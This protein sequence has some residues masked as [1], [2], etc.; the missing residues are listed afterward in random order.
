[1]CGGVQPSEKTKFTK[2]ECRFGIRESKETS[3]TRAA[4]YAKSQKG[5]DRI[6]LEMADLP[7]LE[8][9]SCVWMMGKKI[10][11]GI[12]NGFLMPGVIEGA[13]RNFELKSDIMW[14]AIYTYMSSYF[15]VYLEGRI[16]LAKLLVI[17]MKYMMIS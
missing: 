1:M 4:A 15:T 16:I 14:F 7:W 6:Y 8:Y 13:F 12:L 9:R 11:M 17:T 2:L 3:E 5:N 10:E